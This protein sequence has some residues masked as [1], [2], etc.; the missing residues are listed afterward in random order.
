MPGV[1]RDH[2]SRQREDFIQIAGIDDDRRAIR[3]GDAQ[4]LPHCVCG[5][6]IE[7]SSRV[8]RDEQARSDAELSRQYQLLLVAA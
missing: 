1:H 2:T 6:D 3:R 8:L 5:P 4:S 7:A